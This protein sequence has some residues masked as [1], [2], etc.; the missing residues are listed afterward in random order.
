M[1]YKLTKKK[2]QLLTKLRRTSGRRYKKFSLP[3]IYG[4][5]STF[6]TK[7]TKVLPKFG[8]NWSAMGTMNVATTASYGKRLMQASSLAK[9]LNKAKITGI[10]KEEFDRLYDW[11]SGKRRKKP[12]PQ[13]WDPLT[14]EYIGKR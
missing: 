9:E 3:S 12:F 11:R 7:M 8:V 10:D 13:D 1:V 14:G 2:K 6:G 4:I 5:K